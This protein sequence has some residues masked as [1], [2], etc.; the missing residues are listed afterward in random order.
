VIYHLPF[1]IYHLPFTDHM[2]ENVNNNSQ[3][4]QKAEQPAQDSGQDSGQVEDIFEGVDTGEGIKKQE[5]KEKETGSAKVSPKPV[6][7]G[8]I[9][10]LFFVTLAAVVILGG[11][12]LLSGWIVASL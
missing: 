6:N 7:K 10:F 1:T 5:D 4:P 11:A 3:N 8:L 12:Y 2:F 9:K